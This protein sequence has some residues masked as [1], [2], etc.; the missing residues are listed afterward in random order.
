MTP[1]I[2][3][4]LK[5]LQ[6]IKRLESMLNSGTV[7]KSHVPFIKNKLNRL[8]TEGGEDQRCIS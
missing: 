4:Q 7:P 5:T 2:K 3:N 1:E 6:L 8:T